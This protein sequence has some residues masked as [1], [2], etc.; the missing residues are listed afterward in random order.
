MMLIHLWDAA[1]NM[2]AAKLEAMT[3]RFPLD[4]LTSDVVD[5]RFFLRLRRMIKAAVA[6]A[7]L[8]DALTDDSSA[9]LAKLLAS[10]Y[11]PIG[12]RDSFFD[13][14]DVRA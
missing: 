7:F 2:T 12:Q 1:V 3:Q 4:G 6:E 5:S 9:V 8:Q 14:V 10:G 13:I 11:V